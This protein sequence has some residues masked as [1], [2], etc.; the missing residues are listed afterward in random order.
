[1]SY[2]NTR[3]DNFLQKPT[4]KALQTFT[5]NL[6]FWLGE[7]CEEIDTAKTLIRNMKEHKFEPEEHGYPFFYRKLK[8]SKENLKQ[9]QKIIKDK[10]NATELEQIQLKIQLEDHE[11]AYKYNKKL[12]QVC[13][14]L[15]VYISKRVSQKIQEA[16]YAR[17]GEVEIGH[18]LQLYNYLLK[19]I[20]FQGLTASKTTTSFYSITPYREESLQDFITRYKLT[21]SNLPREISASEQ[22]SILTEAL[23]G[24][25]IMEILQIE[26]HRRSQEQGWEQINIDKYLQVILQT[27]KV[28]SRKIQIKPKKRDCRFFK[29]GHCRRG[30]ECK[31]LHRNLDS[32]Q[33][34]QTSSHDST[35]DYSYFPPNTKD[36]TCLFP[37]TK[38]KW[39]KEGKCKRKHTFQ[40][41]PR[42]ATTNMVVVDPDRITND[43]AATHHN[44]INAKHT[45][46]TTPTN[47]I[48]S[49]YDGRKYSI[50][51]KGNIGKYLKNCLLFNKGTRNLA[52]TGQLADKGAW[53][54][55]TDDR[56]L[57]VPQRIVQPLLSFLEK[58]ALISGPRGTDDLYSYDL[59][60][61]KSM[62]DNKL[63]FND[64]IKYVKTLSNKDK[65][66]I[67]DKNNSNKDT[68][69]QT[70]RTCASNAQDRDSIP[71][72][73]KNIKVGEVKEQRKYELLKKKEKYTMEFHR[74]IG[75]P[76]PL[77][78]FRNQEAYKN[79]K[80]NLM[81]KY[82]PETCNGCA[83]GKLK[84][85]VIAK[86]KKKRKG[87]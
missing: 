69:K 78:F 53:S 16:I 67:N 70:S 57:L 80:K 44:I 66:N 37:A 30:K 84:E 41:I 61:M 27:A 35:I 36:V 32:N 46:S 40:G 33:D 75:H 6:Q 34:D 42:S 51:N 31:W 45:D 83:R 10:H 59:A 20:R 18:G 28:H 87:I 63:Q 13:S 81:L 43:S 29:V 56:S 23:Q 19:Y 49:V 7:Q 21:R 3:V 74:K 4:T 54:I 60:D 52:S 58:C 62:E 39:K 55:F 1:M 5:R 47:T 24:Y 82:L 11:A 25:K 9:K 73:E 8:T 65:K 64:L 12:V 22:W 48:L 14:K 2:P 26:V 77:I 71:C 85:D 86:A 68:L 76:H 38:C 50:K 79:I 17:Q 72:E 15:Q